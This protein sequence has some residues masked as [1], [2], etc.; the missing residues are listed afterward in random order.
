ME[1]YVHK[2]R[3]DSSSRSR[4]RSQWPTCRAQRRAQRR[5]AEGIEKRR[6][7]ANSRSPTDSPRQREKERERES[8][9]ARDA[10]RPRG[11]PSARPKCGVCGAE[12][13]RA[14]PSGHRLTLWSGPLESAR[15]VREAL[16][17]EAA[18]V[19]RLFTTSI[20]FSTPGHA[21]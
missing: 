11:P 2:D 8:R 1:R 9:A 12:D 19:N 14:E 13:N 15:R 4:V 20:T 5:E 18:V 17:R 10:R 16:V 3:Q 21:S 6:K 7:P